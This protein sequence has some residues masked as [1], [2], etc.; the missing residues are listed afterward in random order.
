MYIVLTSTLELSGLQGI[1][2]QRVLPISSAGAHYSY[3]SSH[4]A[5]S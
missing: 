3:L 4:L 5:F 2:Y 1:N